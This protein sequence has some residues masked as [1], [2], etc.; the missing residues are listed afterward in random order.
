MVVYSELF[1]FFVAL[2]VGCL[3]CG[4]YLGASI[5]LYSHTEWEVPNPWA[6]WLRESPEEGRSKDDEESSVPR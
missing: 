4:M 3:L 5:A 6:R 2:T 1:L